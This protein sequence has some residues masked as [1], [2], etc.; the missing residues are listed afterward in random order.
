M[1]TAGSNEY[2]GVIYELVNR[3]STFSM[4]MTVVMILLLLSIW[5][6]SVILYVIYWR[7]ITLLQLLTGRI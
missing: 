6:A 4:V 3:Y 5:C 1:Y 7:I 2:A